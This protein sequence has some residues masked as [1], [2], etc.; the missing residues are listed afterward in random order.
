MQALDVLD[1]P[2]R[3]ETERQNRIHQE[4]L[5]L[6][7]KRAHSN[8]ARKDIHLVGNAGR[9]GQDTSLSANTFDPA[10]VS[11]EWIDKVRQIPDMRSALIPMDEGVDPDAWSKPFSLC[12][13]D[14]EPWLSFY[15]GYRESRLFLQGRRAGGD[16]QDGSQFD[17]PVRALLEL[18]QVSPK[19]ILEPPVQINGLVEYHDLEGELS[20]CRDAALAKAL[21]KVAN[22][23]HESLLRK[24]VD[25]G[26][27][28]GNLLYDAMMGEGHANLIRA[29]EKVYARKPTID[30]LHQMLTTGRVRQSAKRIQAPEPKAAAPQAA[31][32][33][34]VKHEDQEDAVV[35]SLL[36]PPQS[37]PST[38]LSADTDK[39]ATAVK[40]GTAA[41]RKRSILIHLL[42]A[43]ACCA[44]LA[45]LAFAL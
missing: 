10:V 3:W 41:S 11:P 22:E 1:T 8:D 44:A 7:K 37:K 13:A 38:A 29:W 34:E 16:A 14:I 23:V 2:L 30:E 43:L 32:A 33:R 15:R 31:A 20:A 24:A 35:V 18:K 36:Q 5:E 17:F 42:Q 26:R 28:M 6:K 4:A 39:E 12:K 45:A 9:T 19:I 27:E 21:F 40:V 25:K